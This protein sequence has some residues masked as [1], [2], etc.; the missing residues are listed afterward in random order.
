MVKESTKDKIRIITAVIIVITTVICMALCLGGCSNVDTPP[1]S[2][3]DIET[4]RAHNVDYVP[5]FKK[6]F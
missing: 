2:E 4:F 3:R 5:L 1:W 6:E